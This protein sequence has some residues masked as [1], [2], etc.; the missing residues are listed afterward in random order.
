[1]TSPPP[2]RKSLSLIRRKDRA[3]A[4]KE[5]DAAL[6][7]SG[8]IAADLDTIGDTISALSARIEQ[9][10]LSGKTTGAGLQMRF[11]NQHLA[12]SVIEEQQLIAAELRES[13]TNASTR[14]ERAKDAVAKAHKALAALEKDEN[15]R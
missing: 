3:D 5:L 2:R 1:M 7:E 4:L 12:R 14:V 13:A 10:A 15:K 6:E 8:R 11:D 9:A